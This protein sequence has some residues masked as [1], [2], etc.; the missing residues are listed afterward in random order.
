MEG[1]EG[2]SEVEGPEGP[3]EVESSS[4]VLNALGTIMTKM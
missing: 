1:P 3:S 2:P 4:D